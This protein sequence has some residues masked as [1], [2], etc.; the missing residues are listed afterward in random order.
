MSEK[1]CSKCNSETAS[2]SFKRVADKQGLL[3]FYTNPAKAKIFKDHEDLYT[4]FEHMLAL[5]TEKKQWIWIID[6]DGFDTDH[7]LEVR[8]G[9]AIIQL[10]TEQYVRSLREI[11]IINPSVHLRVLLKVV[12]PFLHEEL[13]Q[14]I[15]I[16]EDRPYSILE[17]I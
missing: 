10:I 9:M 6:G 2:Y 14:R 15:R 13:R 16:L 7:L 5:V 8:T 3:T 12:L 11:K 17:F 1:R 4:H